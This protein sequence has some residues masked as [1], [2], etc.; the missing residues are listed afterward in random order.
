V[1]PIGRPLSECHLAYRFI[2]CSLEF[3]FASI[4][5]S[6]WWATTAIALLILYLG[7]SKQQQAT[8]YR[9]TSYTRAP[10]RGSVQGLPHPPE[11]F[12]VCFLLRI[13]EIVLNTDT[14]TSSKVLLLPEMNLYLILD[15]NLVTSPR[16]TG[17][18]ST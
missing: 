8:R 12:T 3:A 16:F 9:W 14:T 2:E 11:G 4:L 5:G 10:Q 7:G 15:L 6:F 18:E 1:E 17:A 13:A